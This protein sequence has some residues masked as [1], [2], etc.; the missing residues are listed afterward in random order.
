MIWFHYSNFGSANIQK[1]STDQTSVLNDDTSFI[2]LVPVFI[3]T[4]SSIGPVP[5]LRDNISHIRPNTVR[6]R[7]IISL[8][9]VAWT[10]EMLWLFLDHVLS[11]LWVRLGSVLIWND[12]MSDIGPVNRHQVSDASDKLSVLV[13][14]GRIKIED[15]SFDHKW[16]YESVGL[17]TI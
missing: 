2:G 17:V 7:V 6:S 9:E 1:N 11:E 14:N 12:N 5:V 16:R 13:P 3:D 10:K 8:K 15:T 4:V